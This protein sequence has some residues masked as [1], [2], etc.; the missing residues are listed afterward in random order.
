MIN[1]FTLIR[2]MFSRKPVRTY[3]PKDF[4][5]YRKFFPKPLSAREKLAA[6]IPTIRDF[7]LCN[8]HLFLVM[9]N[10]LCQFLLMVYRNPLELPD[11]VDYIVGEY[12]SAD[13]ARMAHAGFLLFWLYRTSISLSY[14]IWDLFVI[15]FHSWVPFYRSAWAEKAYWARAIVRTFFTILP[16]ITRSV[17]LVV[18]TAIDMSSFFIICAFVLI[19]GF[20]LGKSLFGSAAIEEDLEEAPKAPATPPVTPRQTSPTTTSIKPAGAG[21]VKVSP[22]AEQYLAARGIVLAGT[23]ANAEDRSINSRFRTSKNRS[24][25]GQTL[26][27][28]TSLQIS[29]ENKKHQAEWLD[30]SLSS[31]ERQLYHTDKDVQRLKILVNYYNKESNTR[32]QIPRG[33]PLL[34]LPPTPRQFTVVQH[35]NAHEK[36]HL[37][38]IVTDYSPQIDWLAGHLQQSNKNLETTLAELKPRL[39]KIETHGLMPMHL[40]YDECKTNL[41]AMAKAT[42]NAWSSAKALEQQCL[43]RIEHL[44][45]EIARYKRMT[46]TYNKVEG[47]RVAFA[48]QAEIIAY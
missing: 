21:Y 1:P 41:E 31:V 8:I 17:S 18:P 11:A 16:V 28:S 5:N 22:K 2:K 29:P 12:K 33:A 9:Y 15:A 36:Q 24:P 10:T 37:K 4:P 26:R 13:G 45:S 27:G 19:V 44:D 43:E 30:A 6:C 46:K 38:S 42:K 14:T 39:D 34:R 40:Q 20:Q 47:K 3:D 32:P 23:H 25:N 35:E 7:I 48:P